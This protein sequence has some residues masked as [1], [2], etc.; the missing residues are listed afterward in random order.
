MIRLSAGRAKNSA[1]RSFVF[2][3]Q[4]VRAGFEPRR[5]CG[6]AR[7]RFQTIWLNGP[8]PENT[9]GGWNATR[10]GS[11]PAR[12]SLLCQQHLRRAEFFA[13]SI[14]DFA[15]VPPIR[16]RAEISSQERQRHRAKKTGAD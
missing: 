4:V 8:V 3:Y 9:P 13:L 12:D 16:L 6:S 14:M 10:N 1:R 15:T 5:G 7:K 11:K 2:F